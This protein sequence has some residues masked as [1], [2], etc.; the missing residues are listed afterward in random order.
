MKTR[1]LFLPYMRR[2]ILLIFV[3]SIYF[4]FSFKV[5]A[6][7]VSAPPTAIKTSYNIKSTWYAKYVDANGIPILGSSAVGD[8]ALL[9]ARSNILR[10]LQ[11]LPTSAKAKLMEKKVRVVILARG[12]V[13]SSIPE[14]K[15]I[16]G[17]TLDNA[18]WGG[19]GPS[20]DLPM[21]AGTEENLI[22]NRG[23]ENTLVHEFAHCLMDVALVTIDARFTAELNAAFAART[24]VSPV[25]WANS[26]AAVNTKEYWA[27]GVQSYFNVNRATIDSS[28]NGI[29]TRAELQTYDPP[30]YALLNRIYG[31][32]GL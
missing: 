7:T 29:D 2:I 27:E 26:H 17:T 6:Q 10:L 31:T 22:D 15:A 16:F 13:A 30:L 12:Q 11:T 14:F 28:H 1:V 9:K 5:M 32:G 3:I 19:F 25:R 18:N 20:R 24:S 4:G 21:C 23:E 8:P